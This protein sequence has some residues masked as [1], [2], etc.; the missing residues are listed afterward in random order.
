MTAGPACT[1][2]SSLC[3]RT[4][5]TNM[6]GSSCPC[7]QLKC[8]TV[9]LPSLYYEIVLFENSWQKLRGAL[10]SCECGGNLTMSIYIG[11]R[12]QQCAHVKRRDHKNDRSME[13]ACS[14]AS[15][16]LLRN[17]PSLPIPNIKFRK[18]LDSDISVPAVIIKLAPVPAGGSNRSDIS[19]PIHGSNTQR[20][21]AY[22]CRCFFLPGSDTYESIN[23]RPPLLL[24]PTSTALTIQHCSCI[25]NQ[26]LVASP[27]PKLILFGL[28]TPLAPLF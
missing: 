6:H 15:V 22:H 3:P 16:A 17:K 25:E 27:R 13:I 18:W 8:Q 9:T 12:F 1:F 20:Y 28:S 2:I 11:P 24:P 23:W 14:N 5:L 19:L 21:W 4:H 10:W 7:H 26:C